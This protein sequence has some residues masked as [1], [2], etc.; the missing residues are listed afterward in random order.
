MPAVFQRKFGER[1]EESLNYAL[2]INN[3]SS[4]RCIRTWSGDVGEGRHPGVSDEAVADRDQDGDSAL[5]GGG[6]VAARIA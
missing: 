1:L 3:R 6:R 5:V 4:G 2:V